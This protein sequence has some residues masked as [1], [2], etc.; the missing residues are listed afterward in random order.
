MY[1]CVLTCRFGTTPRGNLGPRLC[2]KLPARSE[3]AGV[4]DHRF[5]S[6]KARGHVSP[7]LCPSCTT[8]TQPNML[9]LGPVAEIPA[10]QTEHS[11]SIAH[12]V[13]KLHG[14]LGPFAPAEDAPLFRALLTNTPWYGPLPKITAKK[15]PQD[16]RFFKQRTLSR[17]YV[18]VYKRTKST[19]VG[20]SAEKCSSVNGVMR[21]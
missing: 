7:W 4:H 8:L 15:M 14:Y 16:T 13:Q 11:S 3:G 6:Q 17:P 21:P 1:A 9:W 18:S 20:A 2:Q 12:S 10:K 19:L 5:G